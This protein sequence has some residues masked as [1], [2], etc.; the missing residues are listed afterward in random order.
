MPFSVAYVF[1]E[2]KGGGGEEML[3]GAGDSGVYNEE[4]S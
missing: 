2:G 4:K 1:Q 3:Y